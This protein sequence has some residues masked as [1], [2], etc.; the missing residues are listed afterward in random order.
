V[1]TEFRRDLET[2]LN[3]HSMENGSNTPDFILAG[4]LLR[5][6]DAFDST[7]QE[8]EQWYGRDPR[9]GPGSASDKPT[10]AED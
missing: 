8:R 1:K 3:C 5:C 2:A 4:F 7:V 6:L 9:R 10:Q